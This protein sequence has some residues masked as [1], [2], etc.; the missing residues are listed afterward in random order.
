M[1]IYNY[2]ASATRTRKKVLVASDSNPLWELYEEVPSKSQGAKATLKDHMRNIRKSVPTKRYN[3]KSSKEFRHNSCI[4]ND[5]KMTKV[6]KMCE[7]RAAK[8]AKNAKAKKQPG[9][10]QKIPET[11]G[12]AQLKKRITNS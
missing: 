2:E 4:K 5:P 6:Q 9:I 3:Q 11:I 12:I 8:S 7:N 10:N 1:C